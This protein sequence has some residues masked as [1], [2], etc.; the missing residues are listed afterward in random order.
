MASECGG[1]GWVYLH[2]SFLH[3]LDASIELTELV[4]ATTRVREDLHSIQA[5]QDVGAAQYQT[6]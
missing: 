5:H 4:M 6:L 1:M 2:R 3:E